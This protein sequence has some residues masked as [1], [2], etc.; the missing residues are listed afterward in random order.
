[1]KRLITAVVMGL[2]LVGASSASL[3]HAQ[4]NSGELT[5]L[6]L[7]ARTTIVSGRPIVMKTLLLDLEGRPVGGAVIRLVATTKFLGTERDVI[8]DEAVT[9]A[10]GIGKLNF[11]PTRS[12]TAI[13]TARFSGLA[14]YGASEASLTVDV[15]RPVVAHHRTHNGDQSSWANLILILVAGIYC[16]YAMA[17]WQA[18]K[19]FRS[20]LRNENLIGSTPLEGT[21]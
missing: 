13:V 6:S 18:R 8:M 2:V 3:A 17:L 11:S 19:I 16:I 21:R 15:Q 5:R 10:S 1:M 9:D 12:G 4:D 20:G 14:T 7:T